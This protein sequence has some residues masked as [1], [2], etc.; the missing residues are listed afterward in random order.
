M[1][2][3]ARERVQHERGVG[4]RDVLEVLVARL[5]R[6]DDRFDRLDVADHVVRRDERERVGDVA[7]E[8]VAL[9]QRLATWRASAQ[10]PSASSASAAGVAA[11]RR[12]GGGRAEL[13]RPARS[14]SNG[15]RR[16]LRAATP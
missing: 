5:E 9:A 4:D 11:D 13:E 2:R 8:V 12:L 10:R 6:R 15:R 3:R 14:S 16:R 7:R 1:P